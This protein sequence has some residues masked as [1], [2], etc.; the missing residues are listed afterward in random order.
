LE[1]SRQHCHGFVLGTRRRPYGRVTGLTWF[2]ALVAVIDGLTPLPALS[3]TC[4]IAVTN[5]VFPFEHD[6]FVV[7][8][9]CAAPPEPAYRGVL[10]NTNPGPWRVFDEGGPSKTFGHTFTNLPC[11]ITAA[12][13]T[14]HWLPRPIAPILTEDDTICFQATPTPGV[15]EWCSEIDEYLKSQGVFQPTQ[16]W[17]STNWPACNPAVFDLSSL[18]PSGLG[19]TN[20]IPSLNSRGELDVFV[21]DETV[22]GYL[23]LEVVT[24]QDNDCNMNC[25]DDAT[26]ISEGT[27]EDVNCNGVPDECEGDVTFEIICS[28]TSETVSAGGAP[29]CCKTYTFVATVNNGCGTPTVVNDYNGVIG[30]EL[31]DCFPVGTHAVTFTATDDNGHVVSC[32][33]FLAVEDNSPPTITPK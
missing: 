9:D 13:L 20:L 1:D 18:P 27:S 2:I 3:Q 23:E 16:E 4:T 17:N 33:S 25:V 24:C 15:F 26:D 21:Q 14:V 28:T 31:T 6:P 30:L 29:E 11:N 22:V 19:A 12:T 5:I 32:T 7:D 8:T 10:L